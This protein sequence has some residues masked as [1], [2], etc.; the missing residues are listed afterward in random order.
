MEDCKVNYD[1]TVR[2]AGGS[3]VQFLYGEDGMSSIKLEDQTVHYIEYD[4][5]KFQR[6]YLLS[7]D[8]ISLEGIIDNDL[9]KKLKK[10]K[11]WEDEC[12]KFYKRLLDDRNYFIEKIFKLKYETKVT[13]PVSLYRIIKNTKDLFHDMPTV[14]NLHPVDIINA[15]DKLE[16]DL[17]L[18]SFNHGTKIFGMLLRCYLSP[19]QCIMEHRLNKDSF[20]YI[21]Q[22]INLKFHQ[23]IANPSEMVGVIAAQSI[24]EP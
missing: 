5:I 4:R 10:D 23:A 19:K 24:G 20:E 13:Y 1:L 22:Q 12:I 3:I 21:I 9:L 18:H 11:K 17:S 2:N 8:D 14:S 15:L 16:E 7:L 6:I